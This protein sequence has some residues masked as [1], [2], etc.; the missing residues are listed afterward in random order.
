MLSKQDQKLAKKLA[1]LTLQHGEAG[2]ASIIEVFKKLLAPRPLQQKRQ[3]I[4]YYLKSLRRAY[5]Q[6]VLVIEHAGPISQNDIDRLQQDMA[7]RLN[8]Y[9]TV[10]TQENV[11]LI[12]GLRLSVGDRVFDA[13]I[14]SY[15]Q[16]LENSVT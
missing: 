9:L 15:L 6:T 4:K 5:D 13:S 3:L 1:A 16:R 12:G 8:R 2:I 11:E 7:R 10:R 14:A